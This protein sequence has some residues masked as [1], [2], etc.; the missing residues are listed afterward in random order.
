MKCPVD[1]TSLCEA[2]RGGFKPAACPS[3]QGLWITRDTLSRAFASR[4]P[5]ETLD[6]A[7]PQPPQLKP[8]PGRVRLCPGCNYQLAVRWLH[9]IEIDVCQKCQGIW[10]D[11]GELRQIIASHRQ[12]NTSV[13]GIVQPPLTKIAPT[14]RPAEWFDLVDF[15]C[16]DFLSPLGEILGVMASNGVDASQ[17]VVEFLG[18]A[19]SLLDW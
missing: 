14:N 11:A 9:G 8:G 5:P 15:P 19:L 4:H 16:I 2:E 3:C 18:E 1:D 12:R 6:A 10:L 7:E 13:P 17:A